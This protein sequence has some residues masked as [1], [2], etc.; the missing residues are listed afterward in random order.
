MSLAFFCLNNDAIKME[1]VSKCSF[2]SEMNLISP[3]LHDF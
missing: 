3:I 2:D 1:E